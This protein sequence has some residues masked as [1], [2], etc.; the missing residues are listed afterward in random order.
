MD[1]ASQ[2]DRT[3]CLLPATGSETVVRLK[4]HEVLSAVI[5]LL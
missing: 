1:F 3:F 4:R 5:V 2:L